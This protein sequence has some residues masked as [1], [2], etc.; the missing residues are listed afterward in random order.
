MNFDPLGYYQSL[1]ADQNTD[2]TTLK[3]NYR[4][5]AKFWHPDHN[6]AENALEEFQKISIAYDVLKDAQTRKIYDL[7]SLVYKTADFPDMKAL[8]TYK[9]ANGKETPF[10]RV[11]RLKKVN[12]FKKDSVKEEKLI[13][14]FEDACKFISAITAQNWR[15]GWWGIKSFKENLKALKQ[16]YN[17]INCNQDDNFKMLIHNTAAYLSEGKNDPAWLSAHQAL[18][19]APAGLKETIEYFLSSLPAVHTVIPV[20]NYKHLKFIQLKFLYAV[21]ALAGFAL[22]ISVTPIAMQL[23]KQEKPETIAYYQEVRFNSG[24]ETV[25]DMIT[26]KIFNIPVDTADTTML[27]HTTAAT[28]VMYGPS[29]N[30]DTL[31]TARLMQTVRVTGYTPDQQW[32]RVML[33]NGEMGFIKKQYLKR[34]IGRDIPQDSKIFSDPVR[35]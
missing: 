18:D 12:A 26:S 19:Y 14:T 2:N 13:G 9:A 17:G 28:K 5:M 10:L 3:L 6:Q 33:D 31:T 16:N 22:L 29:D 34:G 7:L 15:K 30:F 20:W 32:Y 4:E 11:F 8:K 35:R 1:K 27:F 24:Q 23:F 25:D 21:A